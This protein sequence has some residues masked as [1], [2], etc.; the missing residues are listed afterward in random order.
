MPTKTVFY[1]GFLFRGGKLNAREG[2]ENFLKDELSECYPVY[3]IHAL[4]RSIVCK[5]CKNQFLHFIY[6]KSAR[7]IYNNILI[8]STMPFC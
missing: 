7:K 1:P 2:E 3:N 6:S 8:F 4:I 5:L